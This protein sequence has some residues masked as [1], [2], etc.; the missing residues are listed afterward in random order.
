MDINAGVT[1]I[2]LKINKIKNHEIIDISRY[3]EYAIWFF[4]NNSETKGFRA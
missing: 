2:N 1:T 3:H 4:V